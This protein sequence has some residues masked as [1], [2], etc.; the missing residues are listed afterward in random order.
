LEN[1]EAVTSG[2]GGAGGASIDSLSVLLDFALVRRV[3]EADGI[4]RFELPEA[5]RQVA[6]E[7]LE[8]SQDGDRVRRAH[9]QRVLQILWAAR[10]WNAAPADVYPAALRLDPDAALAYE[11]ACDHDVQLSLQLAAAWGCLLAADGHLRAMDRLVRRVLGT[12]RVAPAVR[13][14]A[15]RS[16]AIATKTRGDPAGALVLLGEA[17]Q[18]LEHDD[19]PMFTVTLSTRGKVF[20]HLGEYDNA[21][22][23][24]SRA[25]ALAETITDA[26]LAGALVAEAQVRGQAGQVAEATRLLDRVEELGAAE[27]SWAST[28]LDSDRGSIAFSAGRPLEALGFWLNSLASTEARADDSQLLYDLC[29]ICMGLI[30]A[31]R[32][33]DGFE[34]LGVVETHSVQA[35]GSAGFVETVVG[36]ER[37]QSA[38]DALDPAAVEAA[39]ARG[40]AVA[41]AERA[42]HVRA[43]VGAVLG[44]PEIGG[45][46]TA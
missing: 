34:V 11:W 21:I 38:R 46:D 8:R 19:P 36:A 37:L 6:A 13:G 18:C 4:L 25:V 41:P 31:G 26:A 5:L 27:P 23:D 22:A 44:D 24:C 17:L 15:L 40:A 14:L 16:A 7:E 12:D 28:Y 9:A 3:Q 43:L 42:S 45:G 30:A 33:L 2:A 10:M 35:F 29:E 32:P 39:R 20:G 1:I